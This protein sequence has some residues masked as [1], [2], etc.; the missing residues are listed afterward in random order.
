M[1][2]RHLA[3]V[4]AVVL[5]VATL[6]GCSGGSS[7]SSASKKLVVWVDNVRTPG[8]QQYAKAH[9]DADVQV[10]TI[11][12]TPGYLQSKIGLAKRAGSGVP[13]V[14]FL[15]TPA[16]IAALASAPLNYAAPL[17][18][19]IGK[20]TRSGFAAGALAGCTFDGKTYCLR[21]DIGQSVLWYDKTL[22]AKFG[23]DVPKTWAEYQALGKRVAKAHP[24]YVIGEFYGKP[25]AEVYIDSS[26][27]PTRTV[28]AARSVTIDTAD[29]ACTRVADILQPL[30]A[31]KSVSTLDQ[32][33]P[34]FVKIG[35]RNK[36]L[37][38]PGASWYGDFLFK[39][40]YKTPKGQLAA[41]PLPTWPGDTEPRTSSVGGGMFAVSKTDEGAK[42]AA[43]YG[44]VKWLTTDVGYQKTQ[45]TYPAFKPAARAWCE[46]KATDAFYAA[47]PCPVLTRE[48]SLLR[49]TQ[50]MI[51]FQPEWIDTF[52]QTVVAAARSGKSLRAG[53]A[54]WGEQLQAAAKNAG[55]TVSSS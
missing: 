35:T 13:D 1:R 4:T 36:I 14:V 45:P 40:T 54:G 19:L 50:G 37:M 17:D 33:D 16:D 42:L 32:A 31:N 34:A 41:A 27:C 44:L 23:Y 20:D 7:G 52:N 22:M 11:P 2:S 46:A 6:A 47:D 28:T 8:V 48:A 30:V 25:A 15:N 53:L 26:G 3:V 24:G 43:A 9:P 49:E 5:V 51:S 38:M 29:A 12:K 10:V 21:N 55:Y 39:P 18:A